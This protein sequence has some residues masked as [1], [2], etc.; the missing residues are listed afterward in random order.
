MQSLC[1]LVSKS[2]ECILS[3]FEERHFVSMKMINVRDKDYHVLYCSIVDYIHAFISHCSLTI[4]M[5][6]SELLNA[7]LHSNRGAITISM[8]MFQH[9]EIW[10][11]L[12]E[13]SEKIWRGYN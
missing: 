12:I 6:R 10:Q 2:H 1:P 13:M 9:T 8:L 5:D 7:K 3:G 4:I 11:K